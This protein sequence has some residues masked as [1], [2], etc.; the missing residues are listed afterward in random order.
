[1]VVR[2]ALAVSAL[3]AVMVG[4]APSYVI[5]PAAGGRAAAGSTGGVSMAAY[6]ESWQGD[7]DDLSEYLTTIWISIVNQTSHD[8]R[9]R[10]EDFALTDQ[11]GFRYAAVSPYSGQPQVPTRSP[12]SGPRAPAP[13]S[14]QPAPSKTPP[15]PPSGDD[16]PPVPTTGS[17][18]PSGA[19]MDENAWRPD[20]AVHGWA[21][22]MGFARY[23][24]RGGGPRGG[25][26]GRGYRYRPFYGQP[27]LH[28]HVVIGPYPHYYG[29][30]PYW[31]GPYPY[32]WGPYPHYYGPYVYSWDYGYHPEAPS[33]DILRLGLPEGELLPRARVSGFIYFQHAARKPGRLD[34]TWNVHGADGGAI[35]SVTASMMVV[36][37]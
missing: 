4:C 16:A 8:V 36:S 14:R 6:P 7:P 24:R 22:Q 29:P 21:A 27:R 33:A 19:T 13:A 11:S 3:A 31:W 18:A 15:A 37:D 28:G 5:V 25:P 12:S 20:G 32:W 1:M 34:L 10:Y 2:F 35:A 23:G 26:H 30:Y 17:P 9:I